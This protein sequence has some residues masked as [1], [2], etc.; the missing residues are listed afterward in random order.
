MKKSLIIVAMLATLTANVNAVENGFN[1]SYKTKDI[2]ERYTENPYALFVRASKIMDEKNPNYKK[3]LQLFEKS[4]GLG[5][6]E[7]SHNA[8]YIYYNGLGSIEKDIKKAASFFL[9]SAQRGIVDSQM[10]LGQMFVDG[11]GLQVNAE[12]A[13]KWFYKAANSGVL[14]AKYYIANMIFHGKGTSMDSDLGLKILEEVAE[15]TQNRKIFFELGEIHRRGVNSPK[16]YHLA[17]I[18]HEKAANL[19]F[20]KSQKITGDLYRYG[21]GDKANNEK[22]LY[23]YTKAA[24]LNNVESMPL[25][26]EM[27]LYG[28]GT[29]K[30]VMEAEKWFE[31][32]AKNSNSESLYN[33]ASLYMKN[34]HGVDPDYSKAIGFYHKAVNVGNKEAIRELAVIYRKGIDGVLEPDT[35]TY[36]DLMNLYYK[37]GDNKKVEKFNMFTFKDDQDVELEKQKIFHKGDFE[38][39][40]K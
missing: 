39:Y 4:S 31:K 11:S 27:H 10:M 21:R 24:L 36:T 14:E 34:E 20:S 13:Y 29:K 5:I 28:N 26:G 35:F 2:E 32:G 8:G 12:Q 3:A 15:E 1:K 19:G 37:E 38:K 16:D 30:D 22:A 7:A 40:L 25:V 23:W 17:L 18:N 33:L 9:S 6:A